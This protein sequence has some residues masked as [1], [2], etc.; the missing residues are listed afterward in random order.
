MLG[1]PSSW[2]MS[3]PT[4]IRPMAS[5]ERRRRT[6]R[7][8]LR[9]DNVK[10]A[11]TGGA[12][13]GPRTSTSTSGLVATCATQPMM[14]CSATHSSLGAGGHRRRGDSAQGIRLL[15]GRQP[16]RSISAAPPPTKSGIGSTSA[17]SGAM[18]NR[19][20]RRRLR[21]GHTECRRPQFWDTDVPP[22][23]LQQRSQR[24]PFYELHGLRDDVAM[25]M[26][27]QGQG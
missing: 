6:P 15:Q 19:L 18:T 12:D 17:T 21:R 23:H 1:L 22:C 24:R 9:T 16:R 8:T 26:F 7:S 5:P 20:H 3:T 27:T 13:P 4:A 10:S 2:P 14:R 25:F 11:S